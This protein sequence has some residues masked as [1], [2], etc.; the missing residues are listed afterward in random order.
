MQLPRQVETLALPVSRQILRAARDG[1]VSLDDART[2]DADERRQAQVLLVGPRDQ[3]RQH[4]DELLHGLF[5]R[6]VLFI[7]MTPQLELPDFRLGE[8]A[9]LFQIELDDA[10][11]DVGAADIDGNDRVVRLEHPAR[12]QMHG[13]NQAGFVGV[14]ADGHEIDRHLVRFEDQAVRP[15][16][17]SATLLARKPPTTTIRSVSRHA[18]SLRK[19]RMTRASSCAKSSTAPCRT[20]AASGSPCASSESS[21]FLLIS[22]LGSSPNGSSPALRSGLR[23]RSRN[24]RNAPLLARSPSRPSSSFSSTL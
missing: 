6:D 1:A 14:V 15:M 5:A 11:T 8:V 23:Q 16:V 7:G 3:P 9:R 4:V 17:S 22:L 19:R 24:S 20:P 21:F 10:G 18:L 12:R 13:S 2:A